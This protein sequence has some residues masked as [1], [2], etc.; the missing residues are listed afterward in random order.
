MNSIEDQP[1]HP[2]DCNFY[3]ELEAA[4]VKKINSKIIYNE[5]QNEQNQHEGYIVDFIHINK[6]EYLVMA[7]GFTLRLDTIVSLNDKEAPLTSCNIKE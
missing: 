4:A 5:S 7:D 1:Y 6:A 3:D 2:I